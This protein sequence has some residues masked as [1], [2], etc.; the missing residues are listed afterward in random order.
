MVKKRLYSS[1]IQIKMTERDRELLETEAER[2]STTASDIIRQF[3]RTL[4]TE[5]K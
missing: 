4:E 2:K 3:I 5:D 1:Y